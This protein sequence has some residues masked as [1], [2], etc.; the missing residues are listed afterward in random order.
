MASRDAP[1]R[2]VGEGSLSTSTDAKFVLYQ[3]SGEL[4][5]MSPPSWCCHCSATVLKGIATPSPAQNVN[6]GGLWGRVA[7]PQLSK[8]GSSAFSCLQPARR[9]TFPFGLD[10]CL[11]MP[12]QHAEDLLLAGMLVALIPPLVSG[13]FSHFPDLHQNAHLQQSRLSDHP[14]LLSMDSQN[15]LS[16]LAGLLP[17]SLPNKEGLKI[18]C[19]VLTEH[20]LVQ[21]M[22]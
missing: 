2:E 3:F 12:R 1:G 22:S 21:I 17:P 5:V 13:S 9:E 14:N 19:K 8:T 7:S 11:L 6:G 4:G 20:Y 18:E 10:S 16:S 15:T